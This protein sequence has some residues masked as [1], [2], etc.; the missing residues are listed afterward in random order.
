MQLEVQL[1]APTVLVVLIISLFMYTVIS[2]IPFIPITVAGL[3]FGVTGI[4][5]LACGLFTGIIFFF[6]ARRS[7]AKFRY[8]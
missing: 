1:K 7:L 2:T 6:L 4:V 3:H 5:C 8:R